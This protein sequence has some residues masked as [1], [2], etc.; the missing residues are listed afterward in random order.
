MRKIDKIQNNIEEDLQM[1]NKYEK[2]GV[3]PN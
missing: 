1:A 2:W 3:Q